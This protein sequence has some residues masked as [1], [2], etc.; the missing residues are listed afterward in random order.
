M[1][2]I[3]PLDDERALGGA[4]RGGRGLFLTRRLCDQAVLFVIAPLTSPCGRIAVCRGS[5]RLKY[6]PRANSCGT[7]YANYPSPR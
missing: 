3:T 4:R 6:S 5:L 7:P 2:D 1:R